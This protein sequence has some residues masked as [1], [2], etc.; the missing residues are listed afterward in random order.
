MLRNS[1]PARRDFFWGVVVGLS[2]G[3]ATVSEYPA[4]PASAILAVFGLAQVWKGGWPRRWRA[5]AGIFAGAIVCVAVLMAYQ[6]R[7]FGSVLH[8]S[9]AYYQEHFPG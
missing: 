3:W 4:A 1:E 2:A 9:Y 8:P 7:A 6:Y 5:A